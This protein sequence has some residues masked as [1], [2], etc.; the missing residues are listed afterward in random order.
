MLNQYNLYCDFEKR[1]LTVFLIHFL[2][3]VNIFL[4][5]FLTVRFGRKWFL[6]IGCF[7][8]I[9]GLILVS[10][11][12]IYFVSALG[13]AFCNSFV[14]IYFLVGFTYFAEMSTGS[15][16]ALSC[17]L[18]YLSIIAGS[19]S[20]C[21]VVLYVE[22]F[23]VLDIVLIIFLLPLLAI[24][25]T[26]RESMYFLYNNQIKKKLFLVLE[27]VAE[28]NGVS[29]PRLIE[30]IYRKLENT[31]KDPF[32]LR[33]LR[34]SYSYMD[35]SKDFSHYALK[36]TRIPGQV[37]RSTSFNPSYGINS[38]SGFTP[39]KNDQNLNNSLRPSTFLQ[40]AHSREIQDPK[41][42][43]RDR[44]LFERP[45][46]TDFDSLH[47]LD[48]VQS[49]MIKNFDEDVELGSEISYAPEGFGYVYDS[50]V[51]S[52]QNQSQHSKI[53]GKGSQSSKMNQSNPQSKSSMRRKLRKRK[54][55]YF[56]KDLEDNPSIQK[57][58]FAPW[59]KFFKKKRNRQNFISYTFLIISIYLVL[60]ITMMIENIAGFTILE[61]VNIVLTG[62]DFVG[63]MAGLFCGMKLS[64]KWLNIIH[65]FGLFVT[66]LTFVILAS[67]KLN[68][69]PVILCI[70]CRFFRILKKFLTINIF[71][72]KN[73][74]I[75]IKSNLLFTFFRKIIF[76]VNI[77]SKAKKIIY[78]YY[79]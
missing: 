44:H 32:D 69:I 77:N 78:E 38:Q 25:F 49:Q 28:V 58:W 71:I 4:I 48:V 24:S 11:P 54:S 14:D 65:T 73:C 23:F 22:S 31:N 36:F 9:I 15:L 56:K 13:I 6:V 57:R 72:L 76:L 40:N 30:N 21:L 74:K 20:C 12:S 5:S 51:H 47:D 19:F 26:F 3:G 41:F 10:V 29:K 2:G 79:F 61:V 16:R 8:G 64:R 75:I 39:S 18:F 53:S 27:L 1:T 52:S 50:G 7:F 46:G 34:R 67:F 66:T 68:S 70:L 55:K 63:A 43:S 60:N 59:S 17:F 45:P 35:F 37:Y 33:S 62:S 42:H